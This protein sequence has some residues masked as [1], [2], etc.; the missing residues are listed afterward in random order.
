MDVNERITL[1]LEKYADMVKRICFIHTKNDADTDDIF[2]E[3][4]LKYMQHNKPFDSAEH[5]KAWLI[6]VAINKCKDTHKSFW[7]RN[8]T[9]LDET[10]VDAPNE[11]EIKSDVM[12]A[13]LTLP[14]NYRNTIYLFYYEGYTA[15]QIAKMLGKNENTI[16]S[17]LH[18]AKSM[19]KE[20]LRGAANEYF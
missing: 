11:L 16:Y 2:Q 9:Y 8:V 13:V 17:W 6:R 20:R 4:F 15:V 19:L 14:V 1:A 5:E 3:V 12:S 18:R 10:Q 7:R